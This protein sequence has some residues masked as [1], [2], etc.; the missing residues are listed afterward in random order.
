MSEF[1]PKKD[2]SR[3]GDDAGSGKTKV[4]DSSKSHGD[5]LLA[6]LQHSVVC[7]L[8]YPRACEAGEQFKR[9]GSAARALLPRSKEEARQGDCWAR[10]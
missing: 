3:A 5:K 1:K 10:D 4:G 8:I 2:D 9:R 7:G 6:V